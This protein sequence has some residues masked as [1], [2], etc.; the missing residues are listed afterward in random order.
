MVFI[1]HFEF[2]YD[3]LHLNKVKLNILQR[4]V[5]NPSIRVVVSSEISPVKLF[6]FYEDKIKKM[7]KLA[8]KCQD[9]HIENREKVEEVKGDYKNW[10]HL[11]GGFFRITIPIEKKK[12]E[13]E[14]TIL[15]EELEHGQYLEKLSNKYYELFGQKGTIDETTPNIAGEKNVSKLQKDNLNENTQRNDIPPGINEDDYIL[16]IQETSYSYYFAIWNSLSKEERYIVYDIAHDS[17]VNSNNVDGIIDLLQKGILIYDHS[18][19]LMN[20]S[21]TNFVLTKVNSDEALERE[22]ESAKG[23]KWN[24][25]S[26]VILLIIISLIVF[27]SFGKIN[28]LEDV[29]ALLG[30]LAAIITLVLRM[31]GI[32]VFGKGSD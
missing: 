32:F 26:A 6:E 18:L 12:N 2:S 8:L 27:I 25:V 9:H 16:N 13:H 24:T 21:F 11:F 4:L 10:L 29:N 14:I 30:S 28:M 15:N 22:L 31:G 7:E 3:N 17:F 20:E 19:R 23:G 5:T 1:E